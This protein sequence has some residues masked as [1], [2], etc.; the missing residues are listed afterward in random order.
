[1]VYILGVAGAV[2]IVHNTTAATLGLPDNKLYAVVV[3]ISLF[4]MIK[5][6]TSFKMSSN[7]NAVHVGS[8]KNIRF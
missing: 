3:Y 4:D 5:C 6:S 1:M 8:K 2:S 7:A